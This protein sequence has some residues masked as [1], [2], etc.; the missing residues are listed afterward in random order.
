MCA[1]ACLRNA[2]QILR[3]VSGAAQFLP[4]AKFFCVWPPSYSEQPA[5]VVVLSSRLPIVDEPY[6]EAHAGAA[7][8]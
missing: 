7:D 5:L 3:R 2:A 1:R 6:H 8:R 4:A